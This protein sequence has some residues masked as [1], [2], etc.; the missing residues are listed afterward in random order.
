M[1]VTWSYIVQTEEIATGD[2]EEDNHARNSIY[3]QVL[4]NAAHRLEASVRVVRKSSRL[5][6][7]ELIQEQKRIQIAQLKSHK[8]ASLCN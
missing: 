4:R 1:Y 8:R 2:H 3:R 6:T 5:F 7:F